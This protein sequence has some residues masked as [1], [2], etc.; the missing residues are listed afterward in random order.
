MNYYFLKEQN[1]ILFPSMVYR[2]LSKIGMR[3]LSIESVLHSGHRIG[4]A[5]SSSEKKRGYKQ[6]KKIHVETQK[7]SGV[8]KGKDPPNSRHIHTHSRA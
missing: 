2:M 1:L 4:L 3:T 7:H 6:G 8:H 5:Q